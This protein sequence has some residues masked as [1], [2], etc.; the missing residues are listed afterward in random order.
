MTLIQATEHL[1]SL[2]ETDEQ[3]EFM[4]TLFDQIGDLEME[5]DAAIKEKKDQENKADDLEDRVQELENMREYADEIDA[6]IGTISY[7][8]ANVDLSELMNVIADKIDKTSPQK[9]MEYLSFLP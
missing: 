8:T 9:L 4:D 6:G 3:K 2:L 1:K 5:K 7:T